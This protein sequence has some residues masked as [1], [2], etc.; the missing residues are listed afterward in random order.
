[1][2]RST[3]SSQTGSIYLQTAQYLFTCNAY[4]AQRLHYDLHTTSA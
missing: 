2:K 1:V 4:C 3:W